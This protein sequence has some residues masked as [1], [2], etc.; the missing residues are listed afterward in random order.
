MRL[1]NVFAFVIPIFLG[2]CAA[3]ADAQTVPFTLKAA[4]ASRSP[5]IDG[6]LNDPQWKSAAHVQ[7]QWDIAFERPAEER[8]DAYLL[9]DANYLYVAF[10]AKQKE[11]MLATQHAND[12]PLTTD[13]VVDVYL[14]P[15]GDTGNEYQFASNPIGTRYE[16]STENTAFAPRWEAV[17]KPT[18]DGYIVTERIPLNVMRGDGRSTWRVQ[19]DRRIR[20]ANELLEW[21]HSSAQGSTDTS[22]FAG[23]L[24]GMEVASRNARTKPRLSVYALGEAATPSAG[25]S[26]SR[27]GA[28]WRYR[29]RKPHRSSRRFIPTIPTSNSISKASRRP[30]FHAATP[31]F[32]RSSPRAQAS[33]TISIATTASTIRC[34]IRPRSRRPETATRLRE[35]RALLPLRRLMRSATIATTTHSRSSGSR[36]I[37]AISRCFNA[38]RSICPVFMT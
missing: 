18:A 9:V 16:Y 12:Q 5:A 17:A 25:G 28:T 10:V 3:R 22:I 20:A 2:V 29:L 6:T 35:S 7:L 14:W 11:A 31:R 4:L 15:A 30:R 32:G 21:S 13:D 1:R 38:R 26:T 8:T 33:I 19:F 27:L 34:S 23:Y 24:N 36:A 37:T